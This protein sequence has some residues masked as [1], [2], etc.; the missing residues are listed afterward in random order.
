M[1]TYNGRYRTL[2][3]IEIAEVVRVD[4][5]NNSLDTWYHL[6]PHKAN[7]LGYNVQVKF[8][9]TDGGGFQVQK[10]AL[11]SHRDMGLGRANGAYDNVYKYMTRKVDQVRIHTASILSVPGVVTAAVG[12][13]SLLLSCIVGVWSDA[14]IVR[15]KKAN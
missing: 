5:D 12:S 1:F 10:S 11:L 15:R 3:I 2:L 13:I 14:D 6:A 9:S 4:E 7:L 8:M